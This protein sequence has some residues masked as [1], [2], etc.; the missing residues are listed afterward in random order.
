MSKTFKD[1]AQL[2]AYLNKQ[3]LDVLEKEGLQE[4][5]KTMQEKVKTEVYDAYGPNNGEPYVYERRKT[6]NGGLQNENSIVITNKRS[7]GDGVGVDI[8]NIA[9]GERGYRLDEVI[10]YGHEGSRG[11]E[12]T[13]NRD[14][15]SPEFLKPRRFVAETEKQ[16]IQ[17][18]AIRNVLEQGL[19][20][21]GIDVDKV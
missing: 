5:R 11:Y 7:T 2:E 18:D 9:T 6:K 1:L 15:D 12:Y 14:T 13:R 20:K 8:E 19:K 17:D 3:M 10:E 21:R 16:L 4:V